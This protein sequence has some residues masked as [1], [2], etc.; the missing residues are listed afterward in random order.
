MPGGSELSPAGLESLETLLASALDP[1]GNTAIHELYERLEAS[2]A[3]LGPHYYLSLLATH[4]DHRGRGV[5]QE[6]LA[7]DLARW[8]AAGVPAYL[9]S[10]NPATTIDTRE[11]ASG[12][13]AA[14]RRSA[15]GSGSPRC[16]ATWAG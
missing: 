14:S 15:T 16:G 2:R 3:P 10:T 1:D 13:S 11:R 6:L 12:P 9:E 7:E 5:G 4:P 8:D